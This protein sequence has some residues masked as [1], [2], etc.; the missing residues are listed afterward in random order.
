MSFAFIAAMA[1]HAAARMAGEMGEPGRP[2][3]NPV[4]HVFPSP[5][6]ADAMACERVIPPRMSAVA[7][8]TT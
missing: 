4:A 5:D 3:H 7:T 6:R 1:A 2:N 8:E